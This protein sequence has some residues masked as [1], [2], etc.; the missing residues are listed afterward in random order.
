MLSNTILSNTI[1][2]DNTYFTILS[3][4]LIKYIENLLTE[5]ASTILLKFI[6]KYKIKIIKNDVKNINDMFHFVHMY[7]DLGITMNNYK[8]H[9]KDKILGRQDVFNIFIS[10]KCCKRHQIN[11]PAE[12]KPWY[13]TEFHNT[14]HILHPCMCPCR[15]LSRWLCREI[16]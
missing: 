1:L 13:E 4:D 6:S 12:F 9:Y 16:D 8:I 5:W 15:N 11:R 10:C 7:T 14:N 3:S 2:Y